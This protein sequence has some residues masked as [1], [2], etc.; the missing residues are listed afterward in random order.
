MAVLKYRSG[1]EV[2]ILGLIKSGVAGVSSVNGKTG[3]VTGV[4]GTDN[5][6]PY[7]VTS[8]NGK[9]GAVTGVYGNNNPPPYPVTSVNG[10][11][12]DITGL[13]GVNNKPPYPVTSVNGRTG[14][15]TDVYDA[16]NQPPYPVRSVDGKG[17]DVNTFSFIEGSSLPTA[18][19]KSGG[20]T[21]FSYPVQGASSLPQGNTASYQITFDGGA[22]IPVSAS[23][24]GNVYGLQCSIYR[25]STTSFI[26]SITNH[27]MD[28]ADLNGAY[29]CATFSP[30]G[31]TSI[32][33]VTN[34]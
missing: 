4:Y 14:A 6:P 12:G 25:N 31:A 30:N 16:G 28:S 22:P 23:L 15:V 9:T 18:I 19:N 34:A 33:G 13:Y 20:L 27:G 21:C 3:A 8:V 32:T 5:P 29:I 26:V 2:K 10:E 1:D 17:G 24:I 7:P 11:T